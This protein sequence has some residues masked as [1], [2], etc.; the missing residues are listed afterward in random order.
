MKKYS[1]EDLKDLIEKP[2]YVKV[3][4]PN[5]NFKSG[6]AILCINP[7]INLYYAVNTQNYPI[8]AYFDI[9]FELYDSEC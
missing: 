1:L 4:D 5:C 9:K 2:V 6:W 7:A 8:S 3:I